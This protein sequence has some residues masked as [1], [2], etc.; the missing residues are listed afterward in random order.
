M[1]TCIWLICSSIHAWREPPEREAWQATVH[2]VTNSWTQPKQPCVCRCK[3]SFICGSS[4][5]MRVECEGGAAAWF[6]GTVAAPSVQEHR[7]P[8]PQ[9]LWPDQSLL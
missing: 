3:A 4:A 9:E 5:P 8:P 7:L 6:A 2:R 1:A